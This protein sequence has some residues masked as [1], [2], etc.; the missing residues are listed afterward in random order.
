MLCV[1]GSLKGVIIACM[2][3]SGVVLINSAA[4][5]DSPASGGSVVITA[6]IAPVRTIVINDQNKI[7]EVI[8]NGPNNVTPSVYK[9]RLT[10]KPVALTPAIYDQYAVILRN[11]E[12][13]RTGIIYKLDSDA[14]NKPGGWRGLI[15]ISS[16]QSILPKSVHA[17]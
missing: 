7:L 8:S 14:K 2:V 6:V 11:T 12:L 9:N 1:A 16:Y 10:T 3:I 17:L 15:N 5:A 13:H 4:Q